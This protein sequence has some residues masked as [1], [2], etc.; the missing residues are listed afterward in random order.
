MPEDVINLTLSEDETAVAQNKSNKR[1]K[2]N[3]PRTDSPRA[4]TDSDVVLV[5]QIERPRS[6]ADPSDGSLGENEDL[7]IVSADV[8]VSFDRREVLQNLL[9]LVVNWEPKIQN[10]TLL[11]EFIIRMLFLSA[12]LEL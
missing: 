2:L 7:R 11:G 12:D 4:E 6:A 9:Q 1:K 10:L 5:D 3:G 8:E